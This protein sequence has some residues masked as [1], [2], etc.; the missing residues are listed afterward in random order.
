M[1]KDSA[2]RSLSASAGPQA[3][4]AYCARG[5]FIHG[6][7]GLG[8]SSMALRDMVGS[9]ESAPL[10][11]PR[12]KQRPATVNYGACCGNRSVMWLVPGVQTLVFQLR[13][14]G[15]S[16]VASWEDCSRQRSRGQ[17]C[18]LCGC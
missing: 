3:H 4:A 8:V 11:Q 12:G 6:S 1:E 7:R 15:V 13:P 2:D 18:V 17:E 9:R 16:P 10:L 5:Q 14:E